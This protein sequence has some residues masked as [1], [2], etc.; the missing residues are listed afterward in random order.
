MKGHE[1][2]LLA[3]AYKVKIWNDFFENKTRTLKKERTYGVSSMTRHTQAIVLRQSVVSS[4][5]KV[6]FCNIQ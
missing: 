3:S 4:M 2:V 5:G 6:L 1:M